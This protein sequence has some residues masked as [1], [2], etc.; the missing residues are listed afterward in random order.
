VMGQ[1]TAQG[2]RHK[3]QALEA[4]QVFAL[5]AALVTL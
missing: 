2:Q 1:I 3:V 4:G 5:G